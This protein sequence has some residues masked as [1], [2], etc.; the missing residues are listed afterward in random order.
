MTDQTRDTE[1]SAALLKA[2]TA[3]FHSLVA[4]GGDKT[5]LE[6]YSRLLRFLKSARGAFLEDLEHRG[7]SRGHSVGLPT[8]TAEDLRG[9]SLDDISR[10]VNDEATSRKNLE[11]IAIQRFSVPRGSMRSFSNRRMLVD[12][13]RA[14]ID[15]ERTHEAITEV[16]RGQAKRTSA[17]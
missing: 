12:K 4:A 16:A 1:E 13:L 6:Q 3:H 5:V 15:N 8:L 10:L 17:Y 2:L 11:F 7:H 14:L 9:A